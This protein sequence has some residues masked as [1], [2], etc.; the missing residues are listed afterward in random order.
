G[1]LG[2]GSPAVAG[3][4]PRPGPDQPDD[5][6]G[7][8]R[9]RGAHRLRPHLCGQRLGDAALRRPDGPGPGGRLAGA[10]HVRR[11]GADAGRRDLGAGAAGAGP[12]VLGAAG[13]GLDAVFLG[14]RPERGQRRFDRPQYRGDGAGVGRRF[15]ARVPGRLALLRPEPGGPGPFLSLTPCP[16]RSP[17]ANETSTAPRSATTTSSSSSATGRGA[18]WRGRRRRSRYCLAAPAPPP[19]SSNCSNRSWSAATS[20]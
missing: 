12:D 9:A 10:G 4:Y 8:A 18:R 2:P 1:E 3:R 11:P 7:P 17:P 14:R 20:T 19:T 16:L 5:P 13:P 15:P 6:A